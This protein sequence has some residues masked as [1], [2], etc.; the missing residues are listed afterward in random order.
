MFVC[1]CVCVCVCVCVCMRMRCFILVLTTNQIRNFENDN[2]DS[3]IPKYLLEEHLNEEYKTQRHHRNNMDKERGSLAYVPLDRSS[4][5]GPSD[6]DESSV[7]VG[8]L[9][10]ATGADLT[11]LGKI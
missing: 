5:V 8:C 4:T 10:H 11:E 2:P 3:Y 7:C 9:V 6:S 1:M